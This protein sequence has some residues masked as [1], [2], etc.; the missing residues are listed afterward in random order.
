MTAIVSTAESRI[1]QRKAHHLEVCIDPDSGIETGE[2]AFNQLHFLHRS[3][4][5]AHVDQIDSSTNFLGYNLS[6]PLFISCMTGGTANARE[7]NRLLAESA[8]KCAIPV[9]LGSIRILFREEEVFDQFYIRKY[10]PSVP[11]FAN[12]GGQQLSEIDNNQIVEMLKRLEVDAIAVHLNPGQELFQEFGDTDFTNIYDSIKKFVE[13][14]PIPVIVKE[15][16]FG[17]APDEALKLAESGVSLI[18]TAGSGGTNWIQVEANR[19]SGILSESAKAFDS[20]GYSTALLLV[21]YKEIQN[22]S[23]GFNYLASGGLRTGVDLA[24]S[25]ALGAEL[26]GMALPFIRSVSSGGVEETLELFETIKHSFKSVMLLTASK[27][28]EALKNARLV[29]SE[30]LLQQIRAYRSALEI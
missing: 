24:K 3:L 29:Y 25:I 18:D 23:Q 19:Q 4:P 11:I 28:I 27:N 7:A 9:G 22:D 14:S 13:Q 30:Q 8:E 26:G 2:S 21:L 20:W 6:L 16:G 17:I 5:E 15:T 12:I 1:G 10:A